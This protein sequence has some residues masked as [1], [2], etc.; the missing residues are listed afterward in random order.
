M[1]VVDQLQ[2]AQD[3]PAPLAFPSGEEAIGRSVES[4]TLLN[5]I[6]YTFD[7]FFSVEETLQVILENNHVYVA[8]QFPDSLLWASSRLQSTLQSKAN[9][10]NPDVKI[11]ILA[12]TSYGNCCVDEIAAQHF[13]STLIIHYGHACLSSNSNRLSVHYV[14][15]KKPTY[16]DEMISEHLNTILDT[17]PKD[18]EP[19]QRVFVFY[20]PIYHHQVSEIERSLQQAD[21]RFTICE[22]FQTTSNI[23]NSNTNNPCASDESCCKR[24]M[25]EDI[26]EETEIVSIQSFP[27]AECDD[28]NL[29]ESGEIL[30]FGR[31]APNAIRSASDG[32]VILWIGDSSSICLRNLKMRFNSSKFFI[33]QPEK[34]SFEQERILNRA[35][36]QRYGLIGKAKEADIIGIVV[37]TLAVSKYLHMVNYVKHIIKEAGKNYY[38]YVVGKVNPYKLANFPEVGIFVLIACHENSAIDSREFYKPIITPFELQLA[39]VR[40]K[41]WT[42]KY[43]P[44]YRELL[45]EI[46]EERGDEN[47]ELVEEDEYTYSLW[48][49]T[50][51]KN[52]KASS[53]N[54]SSPEGTELSVRNQDTQIISSASGQHYLQSTWKGLEQNIGE[55]KVEKAT[56]GLTGIP[57]QYTSEPAGE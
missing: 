25:E 39:L 35:L 56:M 26:L 28:T 51:I 29:N 15:G 30:I 48:S 22:I 13:L 11:C 1:G 32:T 52:P 17:L 33:W 37:G 21:D 27:G 18:P 5:D 3:T 4:P 10:K 36:M 49:G 45:D 19:H 24:V 44:D 2:M 41:E 6:P 38:L 16:I 14:F 47:I 55:T 34:K 53:A 42:G 50:M 43:I 54:Q 7:D 8:L 40:G 9:E 46:E 12:D 31:K 57:K 23:S 20:D